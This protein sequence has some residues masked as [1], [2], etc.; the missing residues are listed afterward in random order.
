M[1]ADIKSAHTHTY[2][3]NPTHTHP[4]TIKRAAVEKDRR[5]W[6]GETPSSSHIHK[7]RTLVIAHLMRSDL[8]GENN[9]KK[10]TERAI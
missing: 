5:V 7:K 4:F 2:T 3:H 1:C 9:D 8:E 6:R 10:T